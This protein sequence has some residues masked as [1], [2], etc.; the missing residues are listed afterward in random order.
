MKVL[1][2][3]SRSLSNQQE[4]ILTK[5]QEVYIQQSKTWLTII[6]GGAIGPDKI[7]EIFAKSNN[8]QI[9]R[10]IPDWKKHGKK[11]GV[12]RNTDLV[13]ACDYAIIFWDNISKG[14]LDTINK[15]RISN[16]PHLVVNMNIVKNESIYSD[17][18]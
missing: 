11:A 4:T 15:L 6:S 7:G 1:I 2:A 5:L 12:L 10:M 8:I 17:E 18:E 3:G 9:T 14:T 16:T 13:N